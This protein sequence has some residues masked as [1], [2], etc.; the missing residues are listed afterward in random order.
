[1]AGQPSSESYCPNPLP[2]PVAEEDR[3]RA[4]FYALL[5]QF[6]ARPPCAGLLARCEEFG[7]EA[8]TELGAALDALATAAARTTAAA[9]EAE[10]NALFIGLGQGELLPYGSHY[11]CGF[12][13]DK[14]LA[15]LRGDLATLG[16]A[17][18]DGNPEP[19][20]HAAAL[21]ETMAGLILGGFGVPVGS[22]TQCIFFGRHVGSWLPRFFADL[23]KAEA[24]SLFRAVGRLGRIFMDIEAEAYTLA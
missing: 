7:G 8:G 3:L 22:E 23:E 12:L 21:C 2:C 13:H 14:P 15:E 4:E 11:L 17:A 1:M 19:E 24:A 6:L 20:D 9:A 5:A 10:Y 16:V 18:V